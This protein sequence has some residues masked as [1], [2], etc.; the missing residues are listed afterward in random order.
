M[1]VNTSAALLGLG[2]IIG[3]RYS[4]IICAGSFFVWWVIIPLMGTYGSAEIA[5]MEPQD[6]F[7]GYASWA[8]ATFIIKALTAGIMGFLFRM[9]KQKMSAR[10]N[11]ICVIIGGLAGETIMVVGYFLYETAL[12]AF[13]SGGFTK[14]ALYAGAVSSATGIPFNIIQGVVGIVIALA[15]LPVLLQISD[16]RSQIL[17]NPENQSKASL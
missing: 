4:F 14:A 1:S 17:N 7:S 3:A 13:S 8:P 16:I 11:S 6:I 12:A 15:L 2:Y 5:A 10:G 9:L